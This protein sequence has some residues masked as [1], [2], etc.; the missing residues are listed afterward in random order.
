MAPARQAE[1]YFDFISPYAY[2]QFHALERV[3]EDVAITL[4]PV[5]F[6]GLLNHW[7]QLGPAEIPA[8]RRH[9]GMVTR[10]RAE[11]RRIAFRAPPRHPF[12]PL[13]VLRL[14]IALGPTRAT[15]GTIFAHIWAEGQ[16]GQDPASL[17]LLA[18]KLGVHDLE[19]RIAAPE[20]KAAL[21]ANTEA[22]IARGVY[23]V[24]SFAIGDETFWGDDMFELM[25]DWLADPGA[26][27]TAEHRRMRAAEPAADR[28]ARQPG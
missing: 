24:P 7:G 4:R 28:R 26:F 8:K 23:G 1:W 14:A 10:W 12:N 6:A 18:R 9:T 25:L 15:V 5:L 17:A 11:R 16:D 21:R 20:V 3:P 22:A 2:L 27:D 19:A 13:A